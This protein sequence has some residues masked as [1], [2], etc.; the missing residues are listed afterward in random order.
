MSP[1]LPAEQE[2]ETASSSAVVMTTAIEYGN[3]PPPP[4]TFTVINRDVVSNLLQALVKVL[5]DA[6]IKLN[7]FLHTL[8][9][10]PC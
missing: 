3:I 10:T 8:P 9:S 5:H 4:V 6:K 2:E 7:G 1:A